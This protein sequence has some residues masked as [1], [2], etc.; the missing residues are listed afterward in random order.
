MDEMV[1]NA[2]IAAVSLVLGAGLSI[3]ATIKMETHRARTKRLAHLTLLA[4]QIV[5][6]G[7]PDPNVDLD[8]NWV[9]PPIT[10]SNLAQTLLD[11]DLLY[12]PND[13]ELVEKLITWVNAVSAYNALA[14]EM[15]HLAVSGSND[16]RRNASWNGQV[17]K[18][19][20]VAVQRRDQLAKELASMGVVVPPLLSRRSLNEPVPCLEG[21][22]EISSQTRNVETPLP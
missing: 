10:A 14:A 21:D 5:R 3:G 6:V 19:Q 4:K 8:S 12:G 15:S 20:A 1:G 13:S 22:L 16:Y 9:W 17:R 11:G 18:Y 7:D 2:L